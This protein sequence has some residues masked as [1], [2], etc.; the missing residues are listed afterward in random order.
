LKLQLKV[1]T[2]VLIGIAG[3]AYYWTG[4]V[5]IP[6]AG[7]DSIATIIWPGAGIALAAFLLLGNGA[8][9]AVVVP[10]LWTAHT[11]GY[12][13]AGAAITVALASAGEGAL[14]AYLLRR[15]IE[16]DL[17]LRR[18]RGV[19]AF[20]FLGAALPTLVAA[21]SC[22]IIHTLLGMHPWQELPARILVWRQD[23]TGIL[24]VTPLI[25]AWSQK[26]E[27]KRD[28]ARQGESFLLFGGL[29]VICFGAFL[30]WGGLLNGKAPYVY[31]VVPFLLWATIRLGQRASF[32]AG[33]V[34][35]AFAVWGALVPGSWLT[36]TW[37]WGSLVMI[38]GLQL[39]HSAS[40][41]QQRDSNFEQKRLAS[42][43]Q[44]TSD[45]VIITDPRGTIQYIN[46]AGRKLLGLNGEEDV[47]KLDMTDFHP[48]KVMAELRRVG[49]KK[50]VGDGIWSGE[51]LFLSRDG[52]TIPVW[53]VM[54]AHKDS[55][56][57][58]KFLSSIARDLTELKNAQSALHDS[59][60]RFQQAQKMES[61]ALLAG[62]IAHDFNN[63]LGVILGHA[64]LLGEDPEIGIAASRRANGI[65]DAALRA[66]NLTRQLLAFS[67]RQVL[68]PR[69]LNLNSTVR[70]MA[71]M[72]KHM[73]GPNIEV[74]MRLDENLG[75]INIDPGQLEQII[76]NLAV[77]ARDAMPMGGALVIQ[78]A[79]RELDAACAGL[80]EEIRPG[81]YVMLSVSDTGVGMDAETQAR[82][83]EPFFTTKPSGKGT[84]LGLATVYGIAKQSGGHIWVYS[85]QG[86]GTTFG[87]YL[88]RVEQEVHRMADAVPRDLRGHES[89]LLVEDEISLR[90]LISD[91]LSR[92]GYSVL[93]ASPEDAL[94]IAEKDDLRIDVLL[95]DM[96]MP[97]ISGQDLA[98]SCLQMRPNLRVVYMSGYAPEIAE[99]TDT[100][101]HTA[102]VQKPFTS[103]ALLEKLRQV[104]DASKAAAGAKR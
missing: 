34:V 83:F 21:T 65:S 6:P 44:Q 52:R 22:E 78:T 72:L 32:T 101:H 75:N 5:L 82:I 30:G 60:K 55:E 7:T 4:R 40:V 90:S 3:I 49:L 76:M 62:G 61:I 37:V 68:Q 94:S 93:A 57:R 87:I 89:V 45:L 51:S 74:R 67:R 53:Q 50:V 73:I 91:I 19:V 24:V 104:L 63:M 100:L 12:P 86:K 10:S 43:L 38:G 18:I 92:S 70:D 26:V 33:A 69:V 42:V 58:L 23:F 35:A 14:G 54:L 66:A 25:L 79:N 39:F 31:F 85:E 81:Q 95:T 84:G 71:N 13:A 88:P 9:F 99:T 56:G 2:V 16:P 1:R 41:E 15:A 46:S 59:E 28:W 47:S 20:I 17:L 77:N 97:K 103:R 48:E 102:F 80:E 96:A 29:V 36:P 8:V 27:W 64:Q 98:R 11:M